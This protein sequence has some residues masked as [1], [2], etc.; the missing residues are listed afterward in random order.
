MPTGGLQPPSTPLSSRPGSNRTAQGKL[1]QPPSK[2]KRFR[3]PVRSSERPPSHGSGQGGGLP[4]IN[5]AGQ[6]TSQT[7]VQLA[8]ARAAAA[9]RQ[10]LRVQALG[11]AYGSGSALPQMNQ[12]SAVRRP[13]MPLGNR[14]RR[15]SANA[16]NLSLPGGP[17]GSYVPRIDYREG[18]RVPPAAPSARLA[19]RLG[20]APGGPGG[21][22][23]LPTL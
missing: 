23:N 18:S 6:A 8:S 11:E 9:A 10:P 13:M 2:V 21:R 15:N 4:Q 5:V 17:G 20:Q 22:L 19:A 7:P 14:H 16:Q 1:K 3:P 12:R